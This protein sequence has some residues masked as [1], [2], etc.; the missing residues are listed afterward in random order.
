MNSALT[1][2]TKLKYDKVYKSF[3]AWK[4]ANSVNN[5]SEDVLI[6]YFKSLP[7]TLKPSSILAYYSMIKAT[8]K[9]Y[10]GIDISNYRRLL[11]FLKINFEGGQKPIKTSVFTKEQIKEFI[12]TAPDS[13]W[14]DVK[15]S[16]TAPDNSKDSTRS[17]FFH[18]GDM[19]L[20][21]LRSIIFRRIDPSE[22][23][24]HWET[25]K[26]VPV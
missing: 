13:S 7:Q 3:M 10:N 18:S 14:L 19:H 23:G 20:W 4:A 15:V 11:D 12:S 26:F 8:L 25:Q 21:C 17:I 9:V 24:W 6:T 22:G 5:I 1:P 2:G 16:C